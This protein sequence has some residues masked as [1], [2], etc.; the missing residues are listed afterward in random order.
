MAGREGGA[1]PS[2]ASGVLAAKEMV[3][4]LERGESYRSSFPPSPLNSLT[5]FAVLLPSWCTSGGERIGGN[6]VGEDSAKCTDGG[7]GAK[8]VAVVP[9]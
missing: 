5:C 9:D 6:A 8:A 2:A 3:R 4:G 1:D 7:I